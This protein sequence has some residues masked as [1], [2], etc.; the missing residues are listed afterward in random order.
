MFMTINLRLGGIF[1][2]PTGQGYQ[3]H[4]TA[5]DAE[6]WETAI[7]EGVE[8]WDEND[9]AKAMLDYP[10]KLNAVL[11]AVE[12]GH[13]TDR[14][15]QAIDIPTQINE[16][17]YLIDTT[18][19]AEKVIR[20]FLNSDEGQLKWNKGN[21]TEETLDRNNDN[22]VVNVADGC[23]A[24]T[25]VADRMQDTVTRLRRPIDAQNKVRL[26]PI[27]Q[28]WLIDDVVGIISQYMD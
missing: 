10:N 28:S 6:M 7:G 12:Q 23:T 5:L 2:G 16:L 25:T 26:A 11:R 4:D 24:L 1:I 22:T 9:I 19:K 15:E 18:R 21:V 8:G 17:V 14:H 13:P 20:D 27:M 3:E